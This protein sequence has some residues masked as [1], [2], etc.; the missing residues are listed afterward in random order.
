MSRSYV[1][2]SE[3]VTDGH[4]DKLCDQ[5]SDA[6]VGRTLRQDPHARV[7]AECAAS[8]SIVFLSVKSRARASI[9][10]A[11]TA[12]DVIKRVGYESD[13]FDARNCTV[14]TSIDE[15][16]AGNRS[17]GDATD[18]LSAEDQATVFGFA[19]DHT[20]AYL[21][22]PIWLAHKLAARLSQVRRHR[23]HG[24][25]APDGK[26]QVGVELRGGRPHRIHSV[27]IVAA[28][29]S[30]EKP[31]LDD[32]RHALHE[33]VLRPV[34][35]DEPIRPDAETRV[36]LNPDG[37]FA[38]G[39]PAH[40]AGLTGRKNAVDTY[41]GFARHG[42]AALSGKDPGRIDR[43]GAYAARYAAKNVVGAGLA[44]QCEI[45]LSY[46][47]GL[48]RPASV[49][50][51]TFGT[52]RLPDDEIA[53]RVE[54]VFDF[55]VAAVVERLALRELAQRDDDGFFTKLASYGHVGRPELDL[56]WE[57]LDR[58]AELV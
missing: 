31:A 50:V 2:I 53:R 14:M 29:R 49:L 30:V 39:G 45:A 4:P 41:G 10:L 58:V 21:P 52:G 32:L 12:R 47:I 8:T 28:Q 37:L 22:L 34:F 13:T 20:K 42:G 5:I 19:C 1:F 3:S 15:L 7:I 24:Y 25:L 40:H 57:R 9:D 16:G 55:R 6:I 51:Q 54:G 48:A 46:S 43:V 17:N 27:S 44:E 33:H 38:R 18:P 36:A 23:A 11:E 56:P 35:E 26:T